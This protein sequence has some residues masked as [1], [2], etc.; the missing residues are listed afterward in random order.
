MILWNWKVGVRKSRLVLY[1]IYLALHRVESM[2]SVLGIKR[3]PVKLN[4]CK[5]TTVKG[6]L[7]SWQNFSSQIKSKTMQ[8]FSSKE[9]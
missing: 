6:V 8:D 4:K 5:K 2:R 1:F 7:K 3:S 9:T